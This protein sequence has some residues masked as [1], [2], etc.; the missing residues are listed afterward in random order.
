MDQSLVDGASEALQL[1]DLS[2]F[3][4]RR[5]SNIRAD[6]DVMTASSH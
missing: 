3:I 5:T 1:L 2:A 4:M 6:V